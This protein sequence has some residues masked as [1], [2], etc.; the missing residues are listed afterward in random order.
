MLNIHVFSK[1]LSDIV[2][3]NSQLQ[4]KLPTFA[5]HNNHKYIYI[6]IPTKLWIQL[7]DRL[8]ETKQNYLSSILFAFSCQLVESG[9]RSKT[10]GDFYFISNP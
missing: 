2:D 7:T 5:Q 1:C 6:I 9:F 8:T 3:T 10:A 4:G